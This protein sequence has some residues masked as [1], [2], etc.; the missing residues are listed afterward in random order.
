M[1][2]L[3]GLLGIVLILGVA[4]AFSTARKAVNFK[5]VAW[6]I[7][8]QVLFAYVVLKFQFGAYA[9]SKAG[10][11]VEWLLNFAQAGA[12]FVFGSLAD[13]TAP[14]GFVFAFRV[15]PTIIFMAAFFAVLYYLGIMQSSKA[16]PG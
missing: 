11:G 6:G 12:G 3:I 4:F 7:A 2:N 9:M 10:H 16:L 15:L 13:P 1:P 5:V 14:A 8:L